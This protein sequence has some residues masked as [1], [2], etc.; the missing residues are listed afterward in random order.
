MACASPACGT[1]IA[2][3]LA[4]PEASRA[5]VAMI[6]PTE[7]ALVVGTHTAETGARLIPVVTVTAPLE[8]AGTPPATPLPVVWQGS[9]GDGCGVDSPAAGANTGA[10]ARRG[11]E[12]LIP[13]APH[14]QM[15]MAVR[16]SCFLPCQ[17]SPGTPSV[18]A[19]LPGGPVLLSTHYSPNRQ[20]IVHPVTRLLHF[21]G[22]PSVH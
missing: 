14:P 18:T 5:V 13:L 17:S 2:V 9:L 1:G 8:A 19:W 15:S 10:S 12:S 3:A 7:G 21:S 16:Y 20:H 22:S 4:I 6:L 11:A